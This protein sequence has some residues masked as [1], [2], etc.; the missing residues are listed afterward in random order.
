MKGQV[1]KICRILYGMSKAGIMGCGIAMIFILAIISLGK[2]QGQVI[3]ANLDFN[4]T[5]SSWYS[6]LWIVIAI[7]YFVGFLERVGR[8]VIKML[9]G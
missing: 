5:T 4:T 9:K 6:Y 1:T 7:I 2:L 3:N 8:W